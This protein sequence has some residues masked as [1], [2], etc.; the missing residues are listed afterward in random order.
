MEITR[1]NLLKIIKLGRMQFLIAGF[2]LYSLGGLLAGLIMEDFSVFRFLF[3][4]AILMPAHLSVSYSNDYFDQEADSF[5]TTH[6]FTGGSGILLENPHLIPFSHYFSLFLIGLSLSLALLF[7]WYYS[8]LAFFIWALFGN[9]LGYYYSAPPLKLSYRGLGEISTVLT[10]LIIPGFG[11][12]ALTGY[13]DLKILLFSLPLM[14]FQLLFICSVEIPDREADIRG[15]KNNLIVRYGRKTGFRIM[16]FCAV[17]GSILLGLL[18]FSG[19]YPEVINF[20]VILA[21]CMI[22]MVPG[23]YG[24]IKRPVERPEATRLSFLIL[25][26]LVILAL[27]N[28]SYFAYLLFFL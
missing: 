26:S 28:A 27:A 17:S 13:I 19:I 5:N 18:F 16:G 23:V 21:L 22:L 1:N 20:R 25:N 11:Y 12:L 10:G 6:G 14:I 4:Y 7:S 3:G 8:S 2:I 9:L 24:F 15:G